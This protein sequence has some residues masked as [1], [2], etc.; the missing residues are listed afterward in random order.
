MSYSGAALEVTEQTPVSEPLNT[1]AHL[2]S[3]TRLRAAEAR[4][5]FA[6][7]LAGQR[8]Y[9]QRR[10]PMDSESVRRN[11]SIR[12]HDVL[13]KEA[14]RMA[15][16]LHDEAGQLLAA[17]HLKLDELTWNLPQGQR[18]SVWQ[19]KSMLD[20]LEG[21]LR[22]LSHELRPMILDD[23]GLLPAVEFL[24][25]GL[26]KRTG[27]LIELNGSTAGR[28]SARIET[29]LYRIVHEALGNIVKHARAR[30]VR[31]AFLRNA[32]HIQCSVS[33]DGIDLDAGEDLAAK[34]ERSLA[35]LAIRERVEDLSGRLSIRTVRG[36]G[37]KM[38]AAIP[39]D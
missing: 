15:Q 4:F 36:Q 25:Q 37:T 33:D 8:S 29:A 13:E 5:V 39:L 18:D 28:L 20:Q 3:D 27:L 22:R 24:R 7:T 9:E 10:R 14:K 38:V 26:T 32:G 34:R 17:V 12:L 21:G 2:S 31:I 35:L 1:P 11:D 6:R 30:R 23:L 16:S 19:L